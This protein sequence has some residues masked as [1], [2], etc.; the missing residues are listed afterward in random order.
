MCDIIA[1]MSSVLR[2][3]E[4]KETGGPEAAGASVGFKSAYT[5]LGVLDGLYQ[6]LLNTRRMY[7]TYQEGWTATLFAV[8]PNQITEKAMVQKQKL[9]DGFQALSMA[10]HQT[11]ISGIDFEPAATF[12][13]SRRLDLQETWEV[14]EGDMDFAI[15]AGTNMPRQRL[16]SWGCVGEGTYKGRPVA[17][18]MAPQSQVLAAMNRP[19][20]LRDFCREVHAVCSLEHPN[21]CTCYGSLTFNAAGRLCMWMVMEKL[22]MNLHEAIH[23]AINMDSPGPTMINRLD[24]GRDD[25]VQFADLVRGLFSALAYLHAS[26]HGAAM[27]HGGLKPSSVMLDAGHVPKLVLD[28]SLLQSSRSWHVADTSMAAPSTALLVAGANGK[29]RLAQDRETT[30]VMRQRVDEAKLWGEEEWLAPEQV[31]LAV[32]STKSDVF[33]AALLSVFLWSGLTPKQSSVTAFDD[34]VL[35]E[36]NSAQGALTDRP[37]VTP[38]GQAKRIIRDCLHQYPHYRPPAATVCRELAACRQA[39]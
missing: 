24:L 26:V 6:T 4:Q 2:D 9:I 18:K 32:C 33:S 17:V 31:Q 5:H 3:F 16:G 13:T 34:E 1:Q 7:I 8:T 35:S 12:G 28:S 37:V 21:V 15:D 25:P 22:Q 11:K 19:E 36:M 10:I 27:L 30:E 39:S 14:I 38:V 29:E 20:L 23:G